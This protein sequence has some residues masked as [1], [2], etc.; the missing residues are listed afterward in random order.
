MPGKIVVLTKQSGRLGNQLFRLHL[1]MQLSRL[2]SVS[3]SLPFSTTTRLFKLKSTRL[4]PYL[5]LSNKTSIRLKV[6]DIASLRRSSLLQDIESCL[7]AGRDVIIPPELLG[8]GFFDYTFVHPGALLAL[9]N[10]ATVS[11]PLDSIAI[12]YRGKDFAN[13]HPK[14]L[15]TAEFYIEAVK[16]IDI[17]ELRVRIF[18]DDPNAQVVKTLLHSLPNSSLCK[19]KSSARS[20]MQMSKHKYVIASPS[21][22]SFWG[23][24]LGTSSTYVISKEWVSEME[25]AG[26]YFWP[27][28]ARN[29]NSIFNNVI[30]L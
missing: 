5:Y 28:V 19:N 25:K 7:L 13:W 6:S 2:F 27:K 22:F 26:E 11:F 24:L 23:A 20:F 1:A 12:H 30:T 4:T 21:T 3:T 17:P 15:M 16:S 9:K 29:I 8:E 10:K 18:S 14:A